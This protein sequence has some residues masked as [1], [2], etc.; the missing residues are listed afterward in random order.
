MQLRECIS[1]IW[2]PGKAALLD[3]KFAMQLR[4]TRGFCNYSEAP[5]FHLLRVWDITVER[6]LEMSE[7]VTYS[8]VSHCSKSCSRSLQ[9]LSCQAHAPLHISALEISAAVLLL[10]GSWNLVDTPQL[11]RSP[12]HTSPL[13]TRT[14][15]CSPYLSSPYLSSLRTPY[16][17]SVAPHTLP[18]LSRKAEPRVATPR[19]ETQCCAASRSAEPRVATLRR[20]SQRRASSHNAVPGDAMPRRESPHRESRLAGPRAGETHS[21][22]P[23]AF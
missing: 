12:S 16:L 17:S 9:S 1:I 5:P 21:H 18:L 11:S 7:R 10:S 20:E 15:P 22:F 13:L 23:A 4:I 3:W 14:H 6:V 19:G 2:S 8:R